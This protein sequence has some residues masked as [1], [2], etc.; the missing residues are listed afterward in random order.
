MITNSFQ[1]KH[2]NLPKSRTGNKEL[3]ALHYFYQEILPSYQ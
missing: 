2:L 1:Q 3:P